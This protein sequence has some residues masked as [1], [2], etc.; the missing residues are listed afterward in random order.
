MT[1]AAVFLRKVNE[2][3]EQIS[4][5]ILLDTIA[6]VSTPPGQSG[7]ALIRISGPAA[8]WLGDLLFE[9]ISARFTKFSHMKGYSCAPGYWL[10][11]PDNSGSRSR[12]DQVVVTKF[13]SPSSFT[14]EDVMEISCHG[15]TAVKQAI[16]D[17]I[18][19]A[20]I[21][22]AGPGEFTKRAFLNGKLDLAQAE[23]VMDLINSEARMQA[24]AAM[25]QLQGSISTEVTRADQS[26]Y[27][28]LAQTELI[29]EFPEHEETDENLLAL[30]EQIRQ[31]RQNLEHLIASY[32]QGRLL[33]EGMNVVIAGRPNAGK[34]SLLNQLA[35]FE[36][37]IVTEIPG[38]TRDTVQETVDLEGLPIHLT[39]TAGI[40]LSNDPVE[41]LGVERA[42]RAIEAADLVIWLISPP[43]ADI[44]E[45]ISEIKRL[46]ASGLLVKLIRGKEDLPDSASLAS[47]LDRGFADDVVI[48]YSA[49]SGEGLQEI[50]ETIRSVYEDR[51][52]Q[53]SES[54]II[55]NSRHR[56]AAESAVRRLIEAEQAME[57]G[58]TLDLVS[59]LL[60]SAA[61]HLAEI[62]GQSVSEE[63]VQTIFSRFCVGK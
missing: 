13:V 42:R 30:A 18:F 61:E 39:D 7:I 62:T 5:E 59:M 63:I 49:I 58:L 8:D 3:T 37:A 22:A 32:R 56:E 17:S 19:A 26:I 29:L 54:V 23:A 21:A 46:R 28:L 25:K 31:V 27:R 36:R 35:G 34:S 40:R 41:K 1:P 45:E 2:M 12:V 51:G 33:S 55:T 20:G 60:R 11:Q 14:G 44:E 16:L 53:G 9:P 50:K 10:S 43:F 57:Q 4:N 48:A 15:S 24:A 6:A 38:T 52:S 47:W